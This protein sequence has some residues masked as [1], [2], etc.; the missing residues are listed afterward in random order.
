MSSGKGGQ[1]GLVGRI[2]TNDEFIEMI[3][4]KLKRNEQDN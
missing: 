3:A 2:R 4:R 1:D